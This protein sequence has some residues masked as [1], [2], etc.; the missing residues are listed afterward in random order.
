VVAEARDKR[1]EARNNPFAFGGLRLV[2][3]SWLMSEL[4]R[5][6]GD[7]IVVL[8]PLVPLGLRGESL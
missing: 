8:V 7:F 2:D 4:S 5:D 3:F 6:T 1:K